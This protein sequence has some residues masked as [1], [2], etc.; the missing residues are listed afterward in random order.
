[1]RHIIERAS[2]SS[3]SNPQ[4]RVLGV[5]TVAVFPNAPLNEGD[6]TEWTHAKHLPHAAAMVARLGAGK[7]LRCG[8]RI[9]GDGH[10]RRYCAVHEREA[11]ATFR[12]SPDREAIRALLN[13]AGDALRIDQLGAV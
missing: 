1:M 6:P 3:V 4:L 9:A 12:V 2:A 7:C 13:S 11:T 5:A 10:R 8:T